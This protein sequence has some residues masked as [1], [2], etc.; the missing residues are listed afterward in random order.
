M[1]ELTG[2]PIDKLNGGNMDNT[3]IMIVAIICTTLVI[4]AWIGK[5]R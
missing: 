2:E 5:R 4:L 1:W 3:A